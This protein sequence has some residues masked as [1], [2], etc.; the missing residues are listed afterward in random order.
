MSGDGKVIEARIRALLAGQELHV[1]LADVD[2]VVDDL[3]RMHREYQRRKVA[4]MRL[5]VGK[6]LERMVRDAPPLRELTD[7]EEEEE[8]GAVGMGDEVPL[9]QRGNGM[10]ASLTGM[11]AAAGTARSGS[12]KM[13][14]LDGAVDGVMLMGSIRWS[15]V[16]SIRRCWRRAGW[17]GGRRGDGE[18]GSSRSPS[19]DADD[20]AAEE[21]QGGRAAGWN[22]KGTGRGQTGSEQH[23]DAP[24]DHVR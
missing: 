20:R 18:R 15:G 16:G 3:R 4:A 21:A 10:N 6:V 17:P 5:Q 24:A 19:R 12:E 1:A 11:Y 13:G 8:A 2:T 7:E 14:G 9:P 22:E 23:R